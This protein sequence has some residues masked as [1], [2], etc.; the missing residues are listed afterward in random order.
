[1]KRGKKYLEALKKIDRNR[2]YEPGE[3]L[4]LVKELASAKFDETV[5]LSVRLGVDPRHADQQVRGTVGLPHG[6]GKTRRVLVF[7]KGEKVKEAEEAGADV[8]GGEELAEKIRGGWLDFDVAVATPDMMG[9][10][11]KLGKI[12]GPRGLMPNPKSGTVT[13][14]IAR[15]VKELKAGR[16]E[17]RVDKTAIVHGPIGKVSFDLDKLEENFGAFVEALIKAKPPAA[18]GQYLRSIAVS[19]TMGPGIKINPVSVMQKAR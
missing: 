10:V 19:S 6:T 11:G 4:Q 2:L 18:K 8:V 14:D 3:A 15:T 7:A 5:E 9:V 13:F 1:M 12:L 16:I 17:F